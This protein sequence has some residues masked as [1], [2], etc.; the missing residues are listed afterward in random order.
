MVKVVEVVEE[1]EEEEKKQ[2]EVGLEDG[3]F[4][5]KKRTSQLQEGYD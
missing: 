4:L 5:T 3:R 2:N 1:E